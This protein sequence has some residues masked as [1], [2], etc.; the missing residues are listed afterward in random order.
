MN[1]NHPEEI[2]TQA[3]DLIAGAEYALTFGQ[4]FLWIAAWYIVFQLWKLKWA[5]LVMWGDIIDFVLMLYQ[6][7]H[8]FIGYP[9]TPY[10]PTAAMI[11]L[12]IVQV[13]SLAAIVLITV[14]AAMCVRF[15]QLKWKE[16]VANTMPQ[17]TAR[18]LADQTPNVRQGRK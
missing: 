14:G 9:K 1:M 4:A 12:T 18:K 11:E 3:L 15:L 10:S 8:H 16:R 13:I 5:L 17:D 7:R 6:A 2:V